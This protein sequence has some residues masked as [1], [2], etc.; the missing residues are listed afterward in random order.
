MR[1]TLEI[2]ATR[3]HGRRCHDDRGPRSELHCPGIAFGMAAGAICRG[4]G[5]GGGR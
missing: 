3:C 2:L 4:W 5:A 1:R